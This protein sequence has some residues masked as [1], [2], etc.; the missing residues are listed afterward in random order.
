MK[1]VVFVKWV[2][3]DGLMVL[4]H[5]DRK[6]V[7]LFRSKLIELGYSGASLDEL[8]VEVSEEMYAELNETSG[9]ITDEMYDK[10]H[11]SFIDRDEL[12]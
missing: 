12:P 5:E 2:A 7:E 11:L 4:V 8:E 6:S 3:D 1:T 10:Y 9:V